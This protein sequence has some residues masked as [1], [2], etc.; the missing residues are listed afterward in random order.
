MSPAQNLIKIQ[1][2]KKNNNK[3]N[4][5]IRNKSESER[6]RVWESRRSR[7]RSR[8]A[9]LWTCVGEFWFI[10]AF[11]LLLLVCWWFDSAGFVSS[12]FRLGVWLI[13]K[14]VRKKMIN[15]ICS[16]CGV[17][18]RFDEFH[19]IVCEFVALGLCLIWLM[20]LYSYL[21]D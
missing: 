2:K 3:S 14:F 1:S 9:V 17:C 6:L 4:K 19:F 5:K 12:R 8:S 15:G 13:S 16:F 20:N 7:R 11:L 18:S 21:V 10:N